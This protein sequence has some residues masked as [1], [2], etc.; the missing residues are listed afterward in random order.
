MPAKQLPATVLL[1]SM[2]RIQ[3]LVRVCSS[4][5][6]NALMRSHVLLMT[7]CVMVKSL[8]HIPVMPIRQYYMP[9][10]SLTLPPAESQ[11]VT[12]PLLR[13]A[14]SLTLPLHRLMQGQMANQLSTL[15]AHSLLSTPHQVI[16]HSTSLL[17]PTTYQRLWSFG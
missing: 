8:T 10:V 11:S 4:L 13:G 2:F 16:R 7:S 17:L 12:I 1:R 14:K 6:R 5:V 3:H 9:V 15:P